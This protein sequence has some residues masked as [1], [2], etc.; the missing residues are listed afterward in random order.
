MTKLIAALGA[1]F[2]LAGA[3]FAADPA[4]LTDAKIKNFIASMESVK[5]LGHE[6]EASGK[7]DTLEIDAMPKAGEEFRPYTK[8]V[9]ALKEKHP[10]DHQRLAALVK[11][12][13]FSVDSWAET[14]DRV[15]IAYMAEKVAE[16]PESLAHAQ[17]MDPAMLSMV[18]PEMRAQME[19][20]MAMMETVKKAPAADRAALRPHMAALDAE[21]EAAVAAS[22]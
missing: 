19:G 2:I 21:L 14:G 4:P 7:T 8:S 13:G 15:M 12:H 17:A 3:A 9:A 10:A 1:V 16:H 11:P 18:P 22:R 5:A 20:A 6:L